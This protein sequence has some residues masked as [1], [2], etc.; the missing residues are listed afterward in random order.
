MPQISHSLVIAIAA[1]LMAFFSLIQAMFVERAMDRA[2]AELLKS[3][4]R[5]ERMGK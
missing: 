2:I 4:K 5:L 3:L 1:L